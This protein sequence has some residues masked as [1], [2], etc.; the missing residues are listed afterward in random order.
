L[1]AQLRGYGYGLQI[2]RV[3]ANDTS[4]WQALFPAQKNFNKTVEATDSKPD[5]E[6]EA[7]LPITELIP[8]DILLE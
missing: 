7:V 6:S 8:S 2:E 4:K 3:E 5:M 1:L